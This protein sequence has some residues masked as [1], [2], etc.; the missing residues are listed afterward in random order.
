M[1]RRASSKDPMRRWNWSCK[2]ATPR[3]KDSKSIC[4]SER[5]WWIVEMEV[6]NE[7][8]G[9]D[10]QGDGTS[11]VP[12]TLRR[13]AWWM[14][15]DDD[16]NFWP[17]QIIG[18]EYDN[19]KLPSPFILTSFSPVYFTGPIIHCPK[20]LCLRDAGQS[21][22][23]NKL[24]RFRV[25]IPIESHFLRSPLWPLGGDTF[26]GF[27]SSRFLAS[28]SQIVSDGRRWSDAMFVSGHCTIR[29]VP[30]LSIGI[31]C[32]VTYFSLILILT[33]FIFWYPFSKSRKSADVLSSCIQWD[34]N[35]LSN[36]AFPSFVSLLFIRF[37]FPHNIPISRKLMANPILEYK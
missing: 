32:R 27:W 3:W 36:I 6:P 33:N 4:S 2:P 24:L 19:C 20:L 10:S 34:K 1:V 16:M 35:E 11:W 7:G 17:S 12:K 8:V 15:N 23:V 29:N 18:F 28:L 37:F 30:F 25:R 9:A 13:I 26:F 21:R 5:S 31:N 22:G 14:G